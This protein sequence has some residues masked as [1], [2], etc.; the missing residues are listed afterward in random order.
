VSLDGVAMQ[1]MKK[2]LISTMEKFFHL[3]L[4]NVNLVVRVSFV[5]K[6]LLA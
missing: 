4:V 2:D 6:V 5:H 1:M 3:E